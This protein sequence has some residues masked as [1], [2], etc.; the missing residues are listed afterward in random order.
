MG[1]ERASTIL[2][3]GSPLQPSLLKYAD[4]QGL[5]LSPPTDEIA[6]EYKVQYDLEYWGDNAP[7]YGTYGPQRPPEYL[8]KPQRRRI[9]TPTNWPQRSYTRPWPECQA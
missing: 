1:L 9:T 5:A 8:S 4:L 6:E 3:E 2:Q 7:I